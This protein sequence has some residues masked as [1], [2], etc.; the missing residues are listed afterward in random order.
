M[1]SRLS[2]KSAIGNRQSAIILVS[3]LLLSAACLALQAAWAVPTASITQYVRE[4]E[5][6]YSN[7]K[8]LEASFTQTSYAWGR[9]RVESGTVYLA[10]GGRMRW[11]YQG[12]EAKIFLTNGKHVLFYLPA[13]KQLRISSISQIENAPVPLDLLLSHLQLNRFFS[14]VEFADQA[15]HAS[16]GD[17]VI[18]CYPKPKYSQLFR[19]CLI[20]LSPAFDIRKLAVFNLDN[21]T[22]QFVFSHIQRNQP[23]SSSLFSLVPPSGTEV[24]RQ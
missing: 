6:S 23:L 18:R 8:T 15:L 3:C 20:E 1:H 17:H 11:V 16:P 13:E 9:T 4:F 19:S 10:R 2:P 24:I 22:M 7:V 21:S 12:Q 5:R 14:K